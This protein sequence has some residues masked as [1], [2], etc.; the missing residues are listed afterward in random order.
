MEDK[1]TRHWTF[2]DTSDKLKID[3]HEDDPHVFKVSMVEVETGDVETIAIDGA[4]M[5][6]LMIGLNRVPQE[7]W[8][9][10]FK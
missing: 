6:S 10:I 2:V 1:W 7:I 5:R 4:T 3:W 8:A 9:R